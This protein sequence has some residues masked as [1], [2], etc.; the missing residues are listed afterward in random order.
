M[1]VPSGVDHESGVRQQGMCAVFN[2]DG[3]L[4]NSVLEEAGTVL[5]MRFP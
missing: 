5:G 3:V 2:T 4:R 1:V